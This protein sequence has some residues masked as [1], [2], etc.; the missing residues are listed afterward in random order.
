M[1]VF[2]YLDNIDQFSISLFDG[3]YFPE[4]N[5]VFVCLE[6]DFIARIEIFLMGRDDFL[7]LRLPW[8]QLTED[9]LDFSCAHCFYKRAS[10]CVTLCGWSTKQTIPL[11]VLARNQTK[12]RARDLDATGSRQGNASQELEQGS[13]RRRLATGDGEG[14]LAVDTGHLRDQSHE[15]ESRAVREEQS[16]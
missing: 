14:Q 5:V 7:E 3:A 9:G 8:N 2:R 16:R 13:Q 10:H 12:A 15:I 4:Y 11:S 1:G 6:E